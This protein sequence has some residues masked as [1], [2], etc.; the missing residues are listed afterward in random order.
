MGTITHF[1]SSNSI[2]DILSH[3]P[4]SVRI[5]YRKHC[6]STM[7]LEHY[8]PFFFSSIKNIVRWSACPLDQ[9][10]TILR[11]LIP[12]RR[13][14]G[15]WIS[16]VSFEQQKEQETI[17]AMRFQAEIQVQARPF[18]WSID[19]RKNNILIT[20]H[21]G[22]YQDYGVHFRTM[23]SKTQTNQNPI[24]ERKIFIEGIT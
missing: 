9:R 12:R 14:N 20:A 21:Q 10:T 18:P 7:S 8:F 1:I 4:L 15:K 2:L 19:K 23:A 17:S 5:F 6:S 3:L 13:G 11:S 16:L 24:R 22:D